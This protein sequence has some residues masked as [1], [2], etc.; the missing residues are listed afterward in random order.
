MV[1]A[2][3]LETEIVLTQYTTNVEIFTSTK[4]K[5]IPEKIDAIAVDLKNNINTNT[6]SVLEYINNTVV[7]HINSELST[8]TDDHNTITSNLIT[9]Q[10]TF[11]TNITTQQ[12]NFEQSINTQQGTFETNI[13]TQQN[14]YQTSITNQQ[15]DFEN[16]MTGNI[17]NY[18]STQGVG[19]TVEQ[20]NSFMFTGPATA[21]FNINGEID[22]Y[23]SDNVTI[24]NIQY[25]DDSNII[26]FTE[27]VGIDGQLTTKTFNISY[28]SNGNLS[29]ITEII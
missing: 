4:A 29:Q 23:T 11:E 24:S 14:T 15:D 19:Y 6:T 2:Q 10:D 25:N 1:N 8:I 26:S 21:S 20:T 3:P 27:T 16:E 17:A 7:P 13:T 9:Q 5:D 22:S 12:T 28:D 18:I